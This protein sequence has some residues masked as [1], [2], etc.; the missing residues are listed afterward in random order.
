MPIVNYV[1]PY[2]LG[3][4]QETWDITPQCLEIYADAFGEY[5]FIDDKY[6]HAQYE[7]Y[8][9]EHQTCTAMPP[10]EW[11][12]STEYLI[13]HEMAHQWWG[14]MITCET[15]HDVWLN[16][17]MATYSEAIYYEGLYGINAYRSHMASIEYWDDRSVYV[18]DTTNASNVF[19]IVVYHKGAWVMHMLRGLLGDELFLSM[20]RAYGNSQFRYRTITT[21]G[22]ISFCNSYTGLNLDQ[23]FDDWVYGIMYP[24]Y[25]KAIYIEPDLSDGQ[26]WTC[27]NLSQTQT[28]G[29]DVFEMPV[30]LRFYSGTDIIL[31][32]T[33]NND[34]RFQRFA[35]KTT[36]EPDSL[37]IDP[38]NWILNESFN[39]PW[40]YYLLPLPLD[41]ADQYGEYRDTIICQG[42]SGYNQFQIISG[43]LPN[44]LTLNSETGEIYGNPE[45]SGEFSFV[46]K[47]DDTYS[48]YSDQLEFNI[49]I[50]EGLGRPGD[51]NKDENVDILDV[52][53]LINYKYKDGPVPAIPVLAD[54]NADC[55]I[56]ILD[57]VY[58]INYRYKDGPVPQLGCAVIQ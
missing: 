39:M 24:V 52:V 7:N 42:G 15:W 30:D 53:F 11:A 55:T 20:L 29:P 34:S 41:S 32:T 21:E 57:I 6:G 49:Y 4:A 46:A 43:V 23:F 9:M 1:Y 19:N 47:A 17:G 36:D 12:H 22:F 26:Y 13:I 2:F 58:L 10:V 37:V 51:A 5:A 33:I 16:E 25:A 40:S 27:L 8:G 45:E 35:F 56:D 3:E 48:S 14:D 28:Y 38:D 31:D 18:Y 50:R 44:G 54:P